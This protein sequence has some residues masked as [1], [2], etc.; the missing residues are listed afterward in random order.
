MLGAMNLKWYGHASFRITSSDVSI[1]TD[2]YTPETAGYKAISESADIVIISSDND[3]FHCRAD[4]IP[5]QPVIIN[6]LELARSAAPRTEKGI[7][8]HAVQAMEAHNHRFHDPD[9]N[10]M[11]KFDVDGLTV[12]HMGD[13]GNALVHEQLEFFKDVDILL[14]LAGGHPTI[15]LDDLKT[16][17]NAIKPK[18]IIPMHFRT[19]TYKPRNTFWIE[20][21]LKYFDDEQVEFACSSEL[22]LNRQTMPASTKVLVLDYA[23]K[24]P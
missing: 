2:P 17:I 18:L 9:Q 11:Y 5:G 15:E 20:T 24:H 8:F 23:S 19:L 12:G 16:A 10:G 14:A 1:I 4:L 21:F 22:E 7:T 6:A 13:V 3:S